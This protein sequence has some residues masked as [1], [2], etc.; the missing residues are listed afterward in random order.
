M[1]MIS[2]RCISSCFISFFLSLSLSPSSFH[3]PSSSSYSGSTAFSLISFPIRPTSTTAGFAR[4]YF[5][6]SSFLPTSLPQSSQ[7]LPFFRD[8]TRFDLFLSLLSLLFLPFFLSGLIVG[9]CPS[10]SRC[11]TWWCFFPSH[12]SPLHLSIPYFFFPPSFCFFSFS[13]SFSFSFF[14]YLLLFLFLN[15]LFLK[16]TFK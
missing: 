11:L 10:S 16:A 15:S 8:R 1:P 14:F 9:L 6:L 3:L 4:P 5:K 13:F 12:L 2:F 7:V